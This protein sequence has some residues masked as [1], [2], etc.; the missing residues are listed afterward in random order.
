MHIHLVGIAGSMT[1]PLA[2]ALKKQGHFITGS[3]QEKIYPPFSHQLKK[4]QIPTNKTVISKKIDLAIIGSS[5]LSFSNTKSEF[6][7]I[8]NL[9]IPYISATKYVSKYLLK[10]N[11]I[12]VAGSYGKTT[13]SAALVYLLKKA[14]FDPSYMIGGQA[15]NLTESLHFSD[16]DWSVCEADESI[17]GLDTKAKFLYYPV[18]YLIL[19]SANWEHCESYKTEESNRLA[20]RELIERIPNNGVLVYNPHDKT[21][22]SL[23][24]YA[25]CKKISYH[26]TPKNNSLIGKYNQEN[27]GA[28]EALANELQISSSILNKSFQN[29]KGVKRRMEI[30]SQKNEIIFIDDFA[31]S[32]NR[33]E[34]ALKSIKESYP[35]S[36]IKVFYENHASFMQYRSHLEKLSSVLKEANEVV[37]YQ[38]KFNKNIPSQDRLTAK[39][40]LNN[41]PKSIY[42]PLGQD[43][44]KHYQDTLKSGDTLI[45]FSSGGDQGLKIFKKIIS[46]KNRI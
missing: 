13:I 14:S 26:P 22:N 20:F 43:I 33:I 38:L 34:A 6:E 39:D 30:L 15:K 2:I 17:N 42:L 46:L 35:K 24:P 29:F 4:Y 23:L 5:Y 25:K 9:Q 19:T 3:D 41:I 37:I 1:A 27:L 21:V 12:L 7:Q 45:R 28:V 10:K 18:K 40:Y 16:T 44:V 32:A 36:K 8:K 31:Q 11:S